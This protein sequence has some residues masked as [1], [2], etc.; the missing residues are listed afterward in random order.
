MASMPR[1]ELM[2]LNR[3]EVPGIGESI[4]TPALQLGGLHLSGRRESALTTDNGSI[5]KKH[6]LVL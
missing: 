1:V 4:T 3:R 5:P 6:E 2:T